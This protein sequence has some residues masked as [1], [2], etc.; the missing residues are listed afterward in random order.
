MHH[1]GDSH[2]HRD[3]TL[4]AAAQGGEGSG[5]CDQATAFRQPRLPPA[6]GYVAPTV[7]DK[8]TKTHN[9]TGAACVGTLTDSRRLFCLM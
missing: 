5:A 2:E 3:G 4:Q 6:S 8:Y 1:H 7:N 9:R